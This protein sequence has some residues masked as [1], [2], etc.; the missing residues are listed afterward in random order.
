VKEM[1]SGTRT[2]YPDIYQLVAEGDA[3]KISDYVQEHILKDST[4]WYVKGPLVYRGEL[5]LYYKGVA[6]MK[7]H[8]DK[9]LNLLD[10]L[11]MYSLSVIGVLFTKYFPL[12]RQGVAIES[13][14]VTKWQNERLDK[15][16]RS[17][18]SDRGQEKADKRAD[19]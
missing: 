18:K 3:Q 1:V 5:P 11:F 8:W 16:E 12:V 2:L 4:Q 15:L 19:S 9:I 6:E 10:F 7:K 13:V 17:V 14:E